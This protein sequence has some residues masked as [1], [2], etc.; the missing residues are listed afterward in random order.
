MQT[1]PGD[2][3]LTEVAEEL[4][5]AEA[6]IDDLHSQLR[7]KDKQLRAQIRHGDRSQNTIGENSCGT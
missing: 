1:T 5:C 3:R 2:E 4:S 7:Q 6:E